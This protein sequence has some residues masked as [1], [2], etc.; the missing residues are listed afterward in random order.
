MQRVELLFR[1]LLAGF[2]QRV[3]TPELFVEL[4][5]PV[6]LRGVEAV[7]GEPAAVVA[8]AIVGDLLGGEVLRAR[9]WVA[10]RLGFDLAEFLLQCPGV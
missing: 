1:G 3:V 10:V 6:L 4:G 8:P 2:E 9:S 5:L 7:G